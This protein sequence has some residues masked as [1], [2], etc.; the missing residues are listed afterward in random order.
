LCCC[1]ACWYCM[2]SG[3]QLNFVVYFFLSYSMSVSKIGFVYW[4]DI[5]SYCF[6]LLSLF[7]KCIKSI[8]LSMCP[9]VLFVTNISLNIFNILF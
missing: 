4:P 5:F 7:D 8:V 9:N 3:R 2:F 6:Y 1:S